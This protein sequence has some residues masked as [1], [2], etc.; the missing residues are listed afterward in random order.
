[1]KKFFPL[2][3][4]LLVLV[5]TSTLFHYPVH[6]H[7]VLADQPAELF[8]VKIHELRI[9]FEPVV[10]PMLFMLRADQ[11][12]VEMAMIL[13]WTLAFLLVWRIFRTV[14]GGISLKNI[15]AGLWAWLLRVPLVIIIWLAVMALIIFVPLPSNTIINND[16]NAALV[17]MHCHSEWSHDGLIS[18]EKLWRWHKRNGFDAF[19]I[20][21]HNTHKHTLNFVEKQKK[22]ELAARPLVLCGE[23]FSG[24]NHIALLGLLRDFRTN[25]MPDSTAIDSAHANGGVAIVA[26]WFA[27]ERNSIQHYIDLGVDGFEIVNQA[28]GLQYS[29]R[30]FKDIVDHCRHYGLLMTGVCDYH[31]YGSAA[32]AW[33]AFDIPEHK[34]LDM[35][36]TRQ[37]IMAILREHR[38][39]KVRVFMYRDRT[40]LPRRKVFW[41]PVY[42]IVSYFRTL[43][44]WQIISWIV[45]IAA[46]FF[47]Y[48]LST[49]RQPGAR[50]KRRN[51]S[52]LAAFSTAASAFI[53]FMGRR[54]ILKAPAVQGY[55]DI[56]AEFGRQ[57][58]FIGMVFL[59][60]SLAFA[61]FEIFRDR[62]QADTKIKTSK[63][64]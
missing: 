20:T 37:A 35:E 2:W 56:Y 24:S 23:E 29:R 17:N 33:T 44:L 6:I 64:D 50:L 36:K 53:L 32:L 26:H 61:G 15:F 10:G 52:I 43:R 63:A 3:I 55:N 16:V 19:F 42:N 8:D 5:I 28:E 4:V 34:I 27:D 54:L 38:Q 58:L 31:G 12:K 48:H 14:R 11:P 9:L 45:W 60:Y 47:I 18:Q 62:R 57:F 59:L 49:N 30:I 13:L 22:G 40:P 41:S 46:L 51:V 39:D 21:D 1:M 25:G 7:D